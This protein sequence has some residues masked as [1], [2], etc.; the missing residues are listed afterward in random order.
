M[1]QTETKECGYIFNWLTPA[2][3]P[4]LNRDGTNCK[5]EEPIF[6]HLFDFSKVPVREISV[7]SSKFIINTCGTTECGN[8]GACL[9]SGK[10]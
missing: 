6:K 2:A 7:Q 5:V 8:F 1:F 4:K 10:Q 3:C 9:K